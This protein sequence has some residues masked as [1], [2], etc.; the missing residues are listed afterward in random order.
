MISGAKKCIMNIF[1]DNTAGKSKKYC[2]QMKT[3][4]KQKRKTEEQVRTLEEKKARLASST[5]D[6]MKSITE[7]IQ[8]LKKQL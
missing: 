4:Q 2:L 1:L 5:A 3:T 8:I 7:D 6:E